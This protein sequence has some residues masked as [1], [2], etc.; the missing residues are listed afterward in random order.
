MSI[1]IEGSKYAPDTYMEFFDLDASILQDR[2]GDPGQIYYFTNSPLI[3]GAPI[4]WRGNAYTQFPLEISEV[5]NRGDGTAPNRPVLKLSNTNKFLLAAVLSLG[6]LVGMGVT[7]WRT[8]YRFTDAGS[9]P[10]P[11]VHYPVEEWS[12]IKKPAQSKNGLQFELGTALD[13][14]GLK[15]PRQQILRDQGFPGVAKVRLR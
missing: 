3:N 1:E 6:N 7:R 15:L 9:S 5:E 2:L 14:P 13:R 11:L 4:L 8:F 12:I 10:N